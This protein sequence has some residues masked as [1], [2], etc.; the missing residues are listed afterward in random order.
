MIIL[1]ADDLE[2]AAV[3]VSEAVSGIGLRRDELQ[4]EIVVRSPEFGTIHRQPVGIEA[5]GGAQADAAIES[6]EFSE[7][8]AKIEGAF[9]EAL[10]EVEAA[11]ARLPGGADG[12]GAR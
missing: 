8:V 5:M 10:R 4:C 9:A 1:N 6:E 7:F 2:H 12:A 11:T 3:A